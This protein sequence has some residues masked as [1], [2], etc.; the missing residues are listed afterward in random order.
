MLARTVLQFF[1][2]LCETQFGLHITHHVLISCLCFVLQV[3]Q[4]RIYIYIY[5]QY[6]HIYMY[7]M[8]VCIYIHVFLSPVTGYFYHPLGYH[9]QRLTNL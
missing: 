2:N 8:Y 5:V 9:P 4:Y 7:T 3:L 6:A 1:V